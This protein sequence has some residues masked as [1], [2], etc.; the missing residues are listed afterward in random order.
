MRTV[1][2][3]LGNPILSDD[4]V[5]VKAARL[6]SE[7]LQDMP[8][9]REDVTVT[10]L[11]T[12]GFA[13]LEEMVGFERAVIIDAMETGT[14]KPG[15]IR[16]FGRS[17]LSGTRNTF[18]T[19]SS[20]LEVALQMGREIGLDV[21]EDIRVF[22]IEAGDVETFGE[23]LSEPVARALPRVVEMVM[24]ELGLREHTPVSI[25]DESTMPESVSGR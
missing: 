12:G 6:L 16:S 8:R 22:G 20:S 25:H 9:A 13:L 19:H 7:K 15:T 4:S 23:E 21:P 18:S 17:I 5:G 2:I 3:G 10:E 14:H 1:V 11:Y 24:Q